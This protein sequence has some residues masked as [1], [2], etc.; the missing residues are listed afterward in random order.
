M[1]VARE[2]RGTV[3]ILILLMLCDMTTLIAVL[4]IACAAAV[5]KLQRRK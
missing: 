5:L 1:H 3:A 4:W 2:V